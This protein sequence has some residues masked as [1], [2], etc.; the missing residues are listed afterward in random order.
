MLGK[1]EK[2]PQLNIAEIPLIHFIDPNH[3]LCLLTR[4][5]DWEKV[6]RDF[7]GFYSRKG[8][9]SVPVRIMVGLILL[10]QRYH[11]SDKGALAEWLENPYWQNFCGEVYLRHKAPFYHGDF[12]HFRKRIGKE[13]EK[14]IMEL[15]TTIFGEDFS[16]GVSRRK[17]RT[18]MPVHLTARLLYRF[19]HFLMKISMP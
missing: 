3:E 18:D 17:E 10:K 6:D 1:S 15:G 12:S 2:N 5:T 14:K 7:A 9:P 8:A 19:G 4:K 16:R 13:G 11:Y